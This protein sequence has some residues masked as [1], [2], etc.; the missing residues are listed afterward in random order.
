MYHGRALSP[1]YQVKMATHLSHPCVAGAA[2]AAEGTVSLHS[3]KRVASKIARAYFKT[4]S[5]HLRL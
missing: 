3:C 1:K 5:E 2:R 4:A